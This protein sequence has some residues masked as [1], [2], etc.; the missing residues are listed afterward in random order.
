MNR[1]SGNQVIYPTEQQILD[2]FANLP[3][4]VKEEFVPLLEEAHRNYRRVVQQ[5]PENPQNRID[6]LCAMADSIF[7]TQVSKRL[8]ARSGMFEEF[9]RAIG[10]DGGDAELGW[11]YAYRL[12]SLAERGR[13]LAIWHNKIK[14]FLWD[15]IRE[16]ENLWYTPDLVPAG[17]EAFFGPAA[18]GPAACKPEPP[19]KDRKPP[20][21][22]FEAYRAKN[23]T[24]SYDKIAGRIGISRD[25]LFK[26]KEETDWVR[27][28]AYE[29]AAAELGCRPEDL[30]P[31][32]L[33]KRPRQKR[34]SPKPSARVPKTQT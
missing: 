16:A 26:I 24:M 19:V 34:G 25:S 14:A 7:K 28:Y 10:L 31:R 29:A 30:H 4:E 1:S 12:Y 20:E 17:W 32:T 27:E 21:A 15:R 2:Y 13:L 22:F 18:A 6:R 23:P 8:R 5:T 9:Q 11:W 3:T 33:P